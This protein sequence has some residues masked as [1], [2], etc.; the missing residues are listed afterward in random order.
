MAHSSLQNVLRFA[1]RM[2]EAGQGSTSTDADLLKHFS[3][4]HDDLSFAY[5]VE[6]HGSMVWGVCCRV[7]NHAHDAEDCFQ[8]AFLVLARKAGTLQR[9]AS[10]GAWLH[11]VAYRLALRSKST[12]ARRQTEEGRAAAMNPVSC[13][14]EE[15]WQELRKLIDQELE[16][17]PQIYRVPLVLCYLEGKS[18]AEAAKE[19]GWPLGSVKGRLSR[20]RDV[21]RKRLQKRGLTLA[22][23]TLVALLAE[24]AASAAVP[25]TLLMST[26]N[27]ATAFAIGKTVSAS[28]QALALAN[29]LLRA[30]TL[31]SLVK[32][33]FVGVALT[34]TI[35]A[36]AMF[37]GQTF[38]EENAA[39]KLEPH[40]PKNRAQLV[41]PDA[42]RIPPEHVDLAG[43]PLP[44]DAI[45][46]LGSTRFSHGGGIRNVRVS[47]DGKSVITDDMDGIWR[48]DIQ[49]GIQSHTLS[50]KNVQIGWPGSAFDASGDGKVFVVSATHGIDSYSA[51]T[52]AKLATF[53]TRSY[54]NVFVSPD[55]KRL[56]A[57]SRDEHFPVELFDLTI[58]KSMWSSGSYQ[59]P[60]ALA[61]FTS[62][63]KNLVV[64]GWDMLTT[65]P[66]ID[67][68]LRILNA[69]SGTERFAIDLGDAHPREIA[70][71]SDNK[72][73]AINCQLGVK[74][75]ES[76]SNEIRI[77][78]L[79]TGT[80]KLRIAPPL[81][82]SKITR[83]RSFS[84][85][86]FLPGA[87][88]LVTAGNSDELVIW[89]TATGKEE[90][91]L[92][93]GL[94]N[95]SSIALTPDGKTLVVARG[96][97][98]HTIDLA[99]GNIS[100]SADYAPNAMSTAFMDDMA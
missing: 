28:G 23:A 100:A 26:T 47:R 20:G 18:N 40:A 32:S 81:P 29:E 74:N 9:D 17:L 38:V 10:L 86:F 1:R 25:G 80:E 42:N 48:W 13:E 99:S 22:G 71:S 19:L 84:A 76:I 90:R 98:L 87:R 70:V 37:A 82:A 92:G 68:S 39:G 62:D 96:N 43:D 50:G 5:L 16:H 36:S 67:N 63:G 53:G 6:R 66:Q 44:A 69:E 95:A 54:Y 56:A 57:L 41:A 75:A 73:V 60:M 94:S 46:R 35:S 85:A 33:A 93:N 27:A 88:Q 58:G 8:A 11:R 34:L 49:T 59:K 51:T 91:R 77:W 55:G 4:H 45:T 52:G 24:H 83:Q 7:L 64:A 3:I 14:R 30:A 21:L 89:D 78:D 31:G 61:N 79:A 97:R 65:P 72:L 15:S 2:A 12:T